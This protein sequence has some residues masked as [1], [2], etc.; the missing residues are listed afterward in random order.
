[1]VWPRD[2]LFDL[3]RFDEALDAYTQVVLELKPDYAEALLRY[4]NVFFVLK[5]YDKAFEAYEKAL[6]LDSGL[7]GARLGLGNILFDLG[8][9]DEAVAAYDRILA[10]KPESLKRGLGVPMY[11]IS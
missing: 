4:G 9:H 5:N 8:R 3:N 6:T 11:F 1:M 10:V 7:V 2:A